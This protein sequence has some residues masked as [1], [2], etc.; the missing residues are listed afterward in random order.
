MWLATTKKW[1]EEKA[2]KFIAWLGASNVDGLRV[3]RGVQAR[4]LV[5]Y[6]G[7]LVGKHFKWISQLT[8]FSLHWGAC[9]PIT[10]DLWKAVGELGALV[11]YQK[12]LDM[13]QYVVRS[14]DPSQL[15]RNQLNHL[16]CRRPTL[17]LRLQTYSISGRRLIQTRSWSNPNFMSSRTC[18]TMCAVLAPQP[19][20]RSKGSR[21]QTRSFVSAASSPIA[22]H[23]ATI[24]R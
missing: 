12:I 8:V 16:T 19:C 7:N 23:Q 6:K 18:L 11:W 20:M 17:R 24:S 14:L 15:Q 13:D 3:P 10:F 21:H 4:N 5:K 2:E 22:T 1:N 9:N